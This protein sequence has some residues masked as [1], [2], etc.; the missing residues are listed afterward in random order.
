MHGVHH[1]SSTIGNTS[2]NQQKWLW[3]HCDIQ[4]KLEHTFSWYNSSQVSQACSANKSL[5]LLQCRH[6]RRG[7]EHCPMMHISGDIS[8]VI[9]VFSPSMTL[10]TT[11]KSDITAL[12]INSAKDLIISQHKINLITAKPHPNLGDLQPCQRI[13]FNDF[14]GK[15]I[16][17]PHLDYALRPFV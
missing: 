11:R 16:D 4:C 5:S 7:R 6:W 1:S 9:Q 8:F 15:K 13:W 14:N 12:H 10:K 17:Y 3:G 2:A